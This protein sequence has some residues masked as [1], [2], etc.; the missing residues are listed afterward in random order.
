MLLSEIN[1]RED[2][3]VNCEDDRSREPMNVA[4]AQMVVKFKLASLIK[5]QTRFRCR[6]E[7]DGHGQ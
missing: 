7:T 5:L 3:V 2:Y 4:A 6:S 1:C